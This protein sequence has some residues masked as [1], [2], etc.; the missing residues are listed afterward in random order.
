VVGVA[1]GV[2]ARWTSER[3][4]EVEEDM[5]VEVIDQR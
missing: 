2:T 4:G 3:D 5:A 1:E